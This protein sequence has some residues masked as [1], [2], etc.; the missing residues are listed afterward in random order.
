MNNFFSSLFVESAH[1]W[2]IGKTGLGKAGGDIFSGDSIEVI[3]GRVIQAALAIIGVVFLALI[4]Y[5]GI[6]WMTS[7]GEEKKI[8]QARGYIFHS[9]LGFIIVMAAYA[10][11]S[12]LIDALAKPALK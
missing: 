12:Y 6:L 2:E 5:A 10:L 3:V 1:A 4:V 8:Q 11:T 7:Q 9:I